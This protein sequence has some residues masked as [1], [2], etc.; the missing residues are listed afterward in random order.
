[1]GTAERRS[2]ILKLLC[3]R[4]YE[5]IEN[6]AFEF[7]VS[8]RTIRRDIEALS[9]SEPIYTQT[10]RYYG[11]VYVMEDYHME[12]MYMNDRELNVLKKLFI[13]ADRDDSILTHDEKNTLASIISLYSKP[14]F[15]KGK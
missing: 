11:G 6:L 10:G 13:A 12:R 4:R 3:S 7:G 8:E 15:K 1:M 9:I 5:T 14:I 2:G